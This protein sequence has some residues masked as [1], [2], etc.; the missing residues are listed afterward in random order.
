MVFTLVQTAGADTVL[1]T[2]D[3]TFTFTLLDQVDH[4][5]L[6]TGGGDAETIALSLASV[7]V[8]TDFDGDSVVIDGGATVT[9]ENDVPANNAATVNINVDEDELTGLSTGITDGDGTT[10]V[11]TFTGAQIAGLV[12]SGADE[13]VTVSLNAAIDNVATGL[14]SQNV[15][16]LFDVVSPTQVNGV[17]GAR[18]VFTL[19]QTAGADTVLGTVD[20]TFTFTLLDQVDHTP[21]ATGGGDAE[22]IALSLASVFVA[23]DFDGDSVVIDAGATVT[24]ENDVPANNAATVN[25]NVDED[26]LA[27]ALSTGITDGDGTTTV[28]TFTG[29]QIAGLVASGADE[30]VTVSLN[31]AI[32]NVDT[33][34]DSKGENILFDVVSPTQVNGVAG[35]RVVFTL[36]QTAGADTVLG[37]VDDA[38]TFTLLDQIDHTPLATGGGDAETI[39]LSLASVFVATDFDGDSVVID[40][41]ATVTIENDVPA[42]NAATVNINVDEDELATALSTGITDGDGTTTVASFTGAQ[43]IGLV[44]SGADEPVTVSL[45]AAIDNVDTGLDSKGENILFDVVSPTQVNGV[46]GARV[47]FTLVQTAGADTVLGTVDDTF[48]FT[49]LDQVDHTPLATGGG[50]AETIALSLASVFVATD[51]DGD[52]VVID[53]GATVTIEN[54]VPANNAATVNINV[55]E[56]ELT[57]LSTGITDGDGTTT[58]AT[59]TGAQIAG[60]VAS[61]ADEPV[62]VSLNA[63]IDNV[64]TGLFSQERQHPV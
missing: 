50:D 62:T 30:P 41:G 13:P 35:A 6:A 3:D 4:T 20:D 29:A 64:A 5:P 16:I 49:L 9:I 44:A 17:A 60:L 14:F 15:S 42:N 38:F 2:V 21:L 10:T 53:G 8:A 28:A 61:G 46:A 11:A 31:A 45:N 54:D 57:G 22:T 24:I 63:A 19:V 43:I 26:E 7:F 59:F 51:F 36:V 48:T 39:A 32:D 55:D 47:V 58:V 18:V 1:G 25:I 52:S 56:D 12:A 23:T 27:T 34:L 40:G 33:G 37:T